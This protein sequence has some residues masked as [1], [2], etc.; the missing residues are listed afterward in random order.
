MLAMAPVGSS[1]DQWCARATETAT[2]GRTL[3]RGRSTG[4]RR[5]PVADR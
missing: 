3:P 5:P 1:D 2:A 4:A